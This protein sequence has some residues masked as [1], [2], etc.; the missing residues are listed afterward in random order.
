M[1]N[2]PEELADIPSGDE[3][4][5]GQFAAS[6]EGEGEEESYAQ[7]LDQYGGFRKFEEGEV[8]KGTVLK[9]TENDAIVDIGYKSEG[10]I[11]ISQFTLRELIFE[12]KFSN[13]FAELHLCLV[14]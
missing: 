12:T 1:V 8:L 7:L 2:K 6:D 4:G 14:R 3:E 13:T 10:L 5:S 11:P 9:I